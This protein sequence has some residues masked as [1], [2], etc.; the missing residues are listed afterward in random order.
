MLNLIQIMKSLLFFGAAVALLRTTAALLSNQEPQDPHG[1]VVIQDG[2][3]TNESASL[4]LALENVQ[5]VDEESIDSSASNIQDAVLVDIE[6]FDGSGDAGPFAHH[7]PTPKFTIGS[8]TSQ[9][10]IAYV[11]YTD[12][13]DCKSADDVRADVATIAREG[14]TTIRLYS[15]DCSSLTRVGTAAKAHN[16]KLI[17]GIH[18]DDPTVSLAQPQIEEIITWAEGDW[19]QIELIAIGNEA[20][21]NEFVLPTSLASFIATA[22]SDLRQAGYTGPVTTTEPINI[23]YEHAATLCPVIDVAAANIHP[24]FHAGISADMAG[25]YVAEQL[26]LLEWICPG[27]HGVNLETGWPSRGRENGEAVPGVLEQMVAVQGIMRR[28]GGRSVLLGFGDDG[29]KDEGEFGVEGSWG[30]LGSLV[31]E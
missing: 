6:E 2:V 26:G 31:T 15:T 28:A 9:W 17:L 4:A 13:L 14:F 10:A 24:F 27:L 23:L 7:S 22:R 20:I 30:C 16:L 3:R 25:E 5:V 8:T 21:F 18:I 1:Q 12:D 11:P 29:W 19:D